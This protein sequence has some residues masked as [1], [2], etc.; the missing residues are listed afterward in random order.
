MGVNA[1][2][3][4][5]NSKSTEDENWALAEAFYETELLP[6]LLATEKG[7]VLVLDLESRDYAIGADLMEA[8]TLLKE[9]HPGSFGYAFRIGYPAVVT[10]GRKYDVIEL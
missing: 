2:T 9:R 1:M 7:K 10:L 5:S 4:A 3:D 6:K 8:D